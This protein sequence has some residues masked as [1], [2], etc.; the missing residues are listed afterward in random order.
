M[1]YQSAA[2]TTAFIAAP[3]SDNIAKVLGFNASNQFEW[4]VKSFIIDHPINENKYLV[5]TCLEGPEV[6]V[7]YRGEGKIENNSS[8]TIT[9]PEYLDKFASNFTVQITPIYNGKTVNCQYSASRVA[10]N[11]FTVYGENGEF[12]WMVHATR[13]EIVVEPDKK[14]VKIN[15]SGPYLWLENDN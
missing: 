13:G 7:Y 10:N 11:Q 4:S 14:D 5:H 12:Y 6:G 1:L 3:T 15:G 2:N 8:V 9:L